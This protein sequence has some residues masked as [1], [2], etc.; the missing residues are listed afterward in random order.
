MRKLPGSG[1]QVADVAGAHT[2]RGNLFPEL[3]FRQI[4]SDRVSSQRLDWKEQPFRL[5]SV[6]STSH[7]SCK[8]P[9]LPIRRVNPYERPR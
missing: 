4:V 8:S 7:F 2:V 9:L 5:M 3:K 6:G 1:V